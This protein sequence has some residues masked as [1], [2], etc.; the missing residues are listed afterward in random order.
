MR[1]SSGRRRAL[2]LALGIV[3]I[4]A[5]AWSSFS[6]SPKQRA[7]LADW[8]GDGPVG[9]VYHV[10]VADRRAFD[11]WQ[12]DLRK[13]A[14]RAGGRRVYAGDP[15]PIDWERMWVDVLLIDELPNAQAALG[16]LDRATTSADPSVEEL[17]VLALDPASPLVLGV[18]RWAAWFLHTVAPLEA[19]P[20][21]EL[22]PLLS[23]EN[24]AIWSNRETLELAR[25]QDL[26]KPLFAYNLN[27]LREHAAYQVAI[28]ED[29]DVS[30]AEAYSRYG[31][32]L[33]LLRR[34]AYPYYFGEVIGYV[35][36][37]PDAP[38][39]DRWDQLMLIHYPQRLQIFSLVAS[40][41]YA[42]RRHH[43]DAAL[44]RAALRFTT[45]WPEFDHTR[46][47]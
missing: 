7:L 29:P 31:G 5:T 3:A 1:G 18:I 47:E 35:A 40:E 34:G 20:P 43:R 46:F 17:W 37:A 32:A 9:L 23:E 8:P 11:T 10:R 21:S 22:P 13:R 30:G 12:R 36:G 16:A 45:P 33:Q 19:T 14:E 6:P 4:A 25:E 27:Q 28:D 2:G 39:N 38:L 24:P 44:S 41:H 15:D 42:S 26:E